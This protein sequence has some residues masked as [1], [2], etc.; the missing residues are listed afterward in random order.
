MIC[1]LNDLATYYDVTTLLVR[2]LAAHKR[3]ELVLM[4]HSRHEFL[5]AIISHGQASETLF[6]MLAA[7]TRFPGVVSG[8]YGTIEVIQNISQRSLKDSFGILE[9]SMRFCTVFQC[10]NAGHLRRI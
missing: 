3:A 1:R 6:R 4:S 2:Y 7:I 10:L 8:F 5:H 9:N